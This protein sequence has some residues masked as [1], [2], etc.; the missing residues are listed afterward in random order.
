MYS[1]ARVLC[2][3]GLRLYLLYVHDD[4][5]FVYWCILCTHA[6]MTVYSC[7]MYILYSCRYVMYSCVYIC[8]HDCVCLCSHHFDFVFLCLNGCELIS[9]CLFSHVYKNRF[10]YLFLL[11]CELV[12]VS[13]LRIHLM[14]MRTGSG[15]WIR[16]EKK[17]RIRIQVFTDL[18][19]FVY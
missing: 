4:A 10:L 1:V 3:W 16:T 14:L 19:K 15:S 11:V 9:V 6:Y 12:I 2:T 8:V 17:F 7:I 18:L 5:Y 13:V